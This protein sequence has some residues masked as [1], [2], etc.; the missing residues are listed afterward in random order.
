VSQEKAG[1]NTGAWIVGCLGATGVIVAAIIALGAPIAQRAADYYFPALT[2]V[3]NNSS[4][5][6]PTSILLQPQIV[7]TAIPQVQPTPGSSSQVDCSKMIEGE[8]H[9]P[10]LGVE[11]KFE[12]INE[13]RIIHIWSNHWENNLPEYKFFLP[14]GQSVSF[15]SGGGSFWTE[16]PGCNGVAQV[17]YDRDTFEEITFQNYQKYVQQKIIP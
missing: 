6:S 16:K 4:I 8:H 12:P 2:P 1:S 5:A 17:I 11:W 15:M 3:Q 9:F 7:E 13:N 10:I 14:A